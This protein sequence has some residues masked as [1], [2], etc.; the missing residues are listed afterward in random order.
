MVHVGHLGSFQMVLFTGI[1][2]AS[3][4]VNCPLFWPQRYNFLLY[5]FETF[6]SMPL[7][8]ENFSISSWSFAGTNCRSFFHV[9]FVVCIWR[10]KS[11]GFPF[12]TEL[13]LFFPPVSNPPPPHTRHFALDFFSQTHFPPSCFFTSPASNYCVVRQCFYAL[14]FPCPPNGQ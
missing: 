2:C 10:G 9:R 12:P 5:F 13:F 6:L 14:P 7:A 1:F 8:V 3:P 11:F 4:P